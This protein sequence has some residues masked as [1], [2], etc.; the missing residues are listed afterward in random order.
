MRQKDVE[1]K[2]IKTVYESVFIC[3]RSNNYSLFLLDF[4][5]NLLPFIK[6]I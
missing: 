5:T 2:D 6:H 3:R 1:A 4:F